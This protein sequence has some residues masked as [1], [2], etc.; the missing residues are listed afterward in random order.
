[1]CVLLIFF[2]SPPFLFSFSNS[3]WYICLNFILHAFFPHTFFFLSFSGIFASSNLCE[4][5]ASWAAMCDKKSIL[6][7]EKEQVRMKKKIWKY[8]CK[9]FQNLSCPREWNALKFQGDVK[10]STKCVRMSS[11]RAGKP[12][13]SYAGTVFIPSSNLCFGGYF[14]CS[15]YEEH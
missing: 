12:G 9:V 13:T 6:I 10:C 15:S 7:L 2:P 11:L 4:K 8:W 14:F 1:M 3:P 5:F